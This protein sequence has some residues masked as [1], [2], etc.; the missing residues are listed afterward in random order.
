[1]ARSTEEA[2]SSPDEEKNEISGVK[3]EKSSPDPEE[4]QKQYD[5]LNSRFLRLAADFD[6]YKKRM[7]RDINTR[8][9]F[10]VEEF[11]VALIEVIDNFER[12][13]NAEG[14][15]AREGLEQISKLF[16]TILER[17][18]IKRIES[19]GQTFNPEVHEAIAYIPSESD[20]GIIIDEICPGYCM[21][22]KVIR[23]AKVA[24]SKGRETSNGDKSE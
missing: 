6:N 5:E 1:M 10:A 23:C 20:E 14:S 2:S 19:M 8:I 17:H 9:N 7:N 4:L 11:A 18:G 13:L 3:P 22:E 15:S 21:H 24:V 16:E 12:A